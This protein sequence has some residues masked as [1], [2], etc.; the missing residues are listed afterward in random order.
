MMMYDKYSNEYI[1]TRKYIMLLKIME[2]LGVDRIEYSRNGDVYYTHNHSVHVNNYR[3]T[4]KP[5]HSTEFTYI[6]KSP[7]TYDN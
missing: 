6:V 1:D 4:A 5:L 3:A 7:D 2:V